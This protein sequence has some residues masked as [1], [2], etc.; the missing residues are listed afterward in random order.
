M[1]SKI[2]QR[3]SA[4]RW[5][6]ILLFGAFS[7]TGYS[8][9]CQ[10]INGDFETYSGTPTG[11]P[12]WT[13][14]NMPGWKIS[15]GHGHPQAPP[16]RP[17]MEHLLLA[18]L[19]MF[20]ENEA[21][22]GIYTDFTFKKGHTYTLTYNIWMDP[23]DDMG[24][25][26][27]VR[28]SNT[29]TP[30]ADPPL[31]SNLVPSVAGTEI[32]SQENWNASGTWTTITKTFTPTGNYSQ[33]WF[34]P[35]IDKT[36]L[37]PGVADMYLDNIC[38]YE[39]PADPCAVVADFTH[40][41]GEWCHETFSNNSIY[42]VGGGFQVLETH[43]DFGDGETGKGDV[44]SHAYA[45]PGTY[46]V[47]MTLYTSNGSEC[48]KIE[49]SYSIETFAECPA[50]DVMYGATVETSGGNPITF[51]VSNLPN[52]HDDRYGYFWE[53]GD[54]TI[55]SG[56]TI[57]HTYG[58]AGTY[59]VNLTIFYIDSETG[60]CCSHL[61]VTEVSASDIG[62]GGGGGDDPGG[63]SPINEGETDTNLQKISKKTTTR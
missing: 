3:K 41:P 19:D 31:G 53:F 58:A 42:P 8:Q 9:D 56:Q 32:V 11:T 38:I 43:W 35:L 39:V 62:V 25:D 4:F 33:L 57:E 63:W 24:T 2:L 20:G 60:E 27:F 17:D 6:C 14:N 15:H 28:M 21:G 46:T 40:T 34:Y 23:S 45:N 49:T 52:V 54:G 37:F 47:T 36:A 61:I 7:S 1:K 5:I 29:L 12:S 30:N 10:N 59:F 16:T 51:T 44:V 22:S 18:H 26:F 50:C 13:N 48:C 55:G